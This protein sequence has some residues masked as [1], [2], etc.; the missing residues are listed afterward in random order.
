MVVGLFYSILKNFEK[1]MECLDVEELL[2]L[3][4]LGSERLHIV[5]GA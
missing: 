3:Y 4:V 2:V 1:E 5:I